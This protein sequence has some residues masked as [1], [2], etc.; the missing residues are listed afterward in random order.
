MNGSRLNRYRH[1]QICAAHTMH[2]RTLLFTSFGS[3]RLQAIPPPVCGVCC[4]T[5]LYNTPTDTKRTCSCK[6]HVYTATAASTYA[7]PLLSQSR[8]SHFA[9]TALKLVYISVAVA[10]HLVRLAH[11]HA[12]QSMEVKTVKLGA[13]FDTQSDQQTSHTTMCAVKFQPKCVLWKSF[14]DA[15]A[16]KLC[17][18]F[19]MRDIEAQFGV[20]KMRSMQTPSCG[21]DCKYGK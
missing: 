14:V 12:I 2:S 19:R 8:G 3:L 7:R 6:I 18:L 1:C 10:S 16:T 21:T 17:P 4:Y 15:L 20:C 9:I 5:L 11:A 13:N